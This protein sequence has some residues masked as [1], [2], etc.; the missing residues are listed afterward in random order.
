MSRKVHIT[1]YPYTPFKF[2]IFFNNKEDLLEDLKEFKRVPMDYLVE[3][4]EDSIRFTYSSDWEEN[5]AAENKNMDPKYKNLVYTTNKYGFRG[6]LTVE[7][8]TEDITLVSGCSNTWGMGSYEKEIWPYLAYGDN[9]VNIGYPGHSPTGIIRSILGV[10]DFYTPKQVSI[11]FSTVDRVE[12]IKEQIEAEY[13]KFYTY[14]PGLDRS[15]KGTKLQKAYKDFI[16]STSK[17]MYYYWFFTSFEGLIQKC[18]VLNI[19]L[20]V[21]SWDR[22]LED[23]LEHYKFKGYNVIGRSPEMV[24]FPSARD[25]YHMGVEY[26]KEVAKSFLNIRKTSN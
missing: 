16:L 15:H 18:K 22:E 17:H 8:I 10:L 5:A 6:P 25:P 12:V 21:G 24:D 4:T 19:D 20:N 9:Y 23:I 26:H 14:G 7:D 13:P 11:F 2:P 3:Q 1:P